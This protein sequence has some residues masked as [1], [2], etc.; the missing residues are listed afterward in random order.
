MNITK[1]KNARD[2][3]ETTLS[4]NVDNR[5]EAKDLNWQEVPVQSSD[6]AICTYEPQIMLSL[7]IVSV[8]V[9]AMCVQLYCRKKRISRLNGV[10]TG[11]MVEMMPVG[12]QIV[13]ADES[14]RSSENVHPFYW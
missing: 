1:G 7:S 11:Y 2:R 6:L 14:D 8:I 9:F 10:I 5:Y 4:R 12:A 3:C 13:H